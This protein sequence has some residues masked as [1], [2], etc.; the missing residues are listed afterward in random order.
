MTMS[1]PLVG[2]KKAKPA[3]AKKA[4]PDNS[5]DNDPFGINKK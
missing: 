2:K 3:K 1:E 4:E 5:T